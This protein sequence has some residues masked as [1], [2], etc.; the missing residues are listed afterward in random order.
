MFNLDGI[1]ITQVLAGYALPKQPQPTG[2]FVATGYMEFLGTINGK[3]THGF[4]NMVTSIDGSSASGVIRLGLA[5]PA[6][7]NPVNGGQQLSRTQL[8]GAFTKR[9]TRRGT[10]A[11]PMGRAITR[12]TATA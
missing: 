11:A 5:S 7:W 9:R 8:M 4:V 3:A 12:P 10:R 6:L 1:K 2:G